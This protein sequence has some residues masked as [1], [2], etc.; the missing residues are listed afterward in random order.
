MKAE[1]S[2]TL[3]ASSVRPESGRGGMLPSLTR[4]M[5]REPSLSHDFDRGMLGHVIHVID[6]EEPVAGT[7]VMIAAELPAMAVPARL[8]ERELEATHLT[9]SRSGSA[10]HG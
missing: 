5:R 7:E 4:W 10:A 6:V 2:S 1:S 8:I 9:A 3:L